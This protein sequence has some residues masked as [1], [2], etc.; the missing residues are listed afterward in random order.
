MANISDL[1]ENV[2][3]DLLSLLPARELILRC[4]LVCTVWRDV[5]DLATLWKRKCQREV[6]YQEKWDR[7]VQD[8]KIFYFLC[9]LKRNL[10]KN[11]C[12]EEDFQFWKLDV[13][14]GDKWKVENLPGEHGRAFPHQGVHKYFVTSHGRCRKSQLIS[15]K[16]MGYWD[17]LMD[18]I[19]PDI[20][21]QDWYAA[22]FDCGSRY[23]LRVRLLSADYIVLHQFQPEDVLLEQ[24]SDAEWRQIS[25]TFHNYGPG[26]RH[27][28]FYHGGQDT[29]Y[30]AGWY[31]IRVTNS[32]ITIG[33]E[34]AT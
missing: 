34:V 4:R 18:E 24:W 17:Q 26:V 8:W 31:G 9:S 14:E 13:N 28:H 16:N 7:N 6:L 21:I 29:Q 33:P 12:A 22:R 20:T 5:V 11:P 3:V 10:I 15:L 23:S 19:Q 1:P 25:Y 30:W 32:S 27:I 2:L